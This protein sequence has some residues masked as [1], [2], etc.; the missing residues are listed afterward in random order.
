MEI[1]FM[2]FIKKKLSFFSILSMFAFSS[3]N[4][5]AQEGL[6]LTTSDLSP[7]PELKETS[8]ESPLTPQEFNKQADYYLGLINSTVCNMYN[9]AMKQKTRDNLG[10]LVIADYDSFYRVYQ[11]A[12]TTSSF[13]LNSLTDE[14]PRIL[15]FLFP[16]GVK[17]DMSQIHNYT[18]VRD[19]ADAYFALSGNSN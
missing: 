16:H 8:P 3:L 9:A 13:S 5:I 10:D 18:R 7:F 4:C 17:R 2:T 11:E 1:R 12:K 19:F 15:E 6:N 14:T